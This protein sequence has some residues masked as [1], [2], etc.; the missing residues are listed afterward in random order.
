MAL[1]ELLIIIL[2]LF[3]LVV[4]E[5]AAKQSCDDFLQNKN[6]NISKTAI[7]DL[8][9]IDNKV[10]I[11]TCL[12]VFGKERL[13]PGIAEVLWKALVKVRKNVNIIYDF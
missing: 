4:Y 11:K 6:F 3:I 10:K 8:I 7:N 2:I 12:T 9:S 5:N 1:K 13:E